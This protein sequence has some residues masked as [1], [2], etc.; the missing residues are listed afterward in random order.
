MIFLL[1][2]PVFFFT[3]RLSFPFFIFLFC[4]VCALMPSMKNRCKIV[5][6]YNAVQ[7]TVRAFHISPGDDAPHHTNG[8]WQPKE[9]PIL[10]EERITKTKNY[11]IAA[12]VE[13]FLIVVVVVVVIVIALCTAFCMTYCIA[14]GTALKP[15]PRKSAQPDPFRI[16]P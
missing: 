8:V 12:K 11:K 16:F 3:F 6:R 9:N 7:S 5:Q 4:F 15:K 14:L 10:F 2:A 13:L 1:F